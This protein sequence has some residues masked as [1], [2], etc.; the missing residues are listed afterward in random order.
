MDGPNNTTYVRCRSVSVQLRSVQLSTSRRLRRW[1][2]YWWPVVGWPEE[3]RRRGRLRWLVLKRSRSPYFH[4][5]TSFTDSLYMQFYE[6]DSRWAGWVPG[7]ILS[8]TA[9]DCN[10]VFAHIYLFC[11][12][13]AISSCR[14]LI[15]SQFVISV[16]SSLCSGLTHKSTT[17]RETMHACIPGT[18]RWVAR[19]GE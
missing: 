3:K 17:R 6:A 8:T 7:K 19:A 15:R 12:W 11:T 1:R 5:F 9:R 16:L 10:F 18:W 13:R 2:W 4:P 14:V